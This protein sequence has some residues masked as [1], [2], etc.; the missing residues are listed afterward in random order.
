[1][2]ARIHRGA[3]EI[4]GNCVELEAYGKKLLLDLGRPLAL[5]IGAPAAL[6]EVLSS[7]R[8]PH[9]LGIVITHPHLDHYGLL[10]EVEAHIPV[11]I[12]EAASRILSESAFFGPFGIHLQ[13]AGH[14]R[15][16]EAFEVGPFRITPYLNDHSAFDAYSL[17]IEAAGRR[18]FYT[19]D[20]RAHGRKAELFNE[21]I[22]R[23]PTGVHAL[24]MEGTH[25]REGV[26]IDPGPGVPYSRS[27]P[28][29]TAGA[30]LAGASS[31]TASSS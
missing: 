21:F 17:L 24:L 7:G 29:S 8:D 6:P 13:P 19:G 15:H 3:S 10:L 28:V 11:F 30:P 23:P 1:M 25:V 2:R 26:V 9:L 5:P 27:I 12:G 22:R 16:R 18:L 14:L 4:G 31:G 20:F